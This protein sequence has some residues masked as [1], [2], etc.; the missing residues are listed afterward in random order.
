LS[1]NG[2]FLVSTPNK[3]FY[4]ESR[5]HEGP[6]PFHVHEFEFEEFRSE[7]LAVFPEVTLF[8]ENHVEAIAFEPFEPGMGESLHIA[9]ELNPQ[10]AHF[11]V[12]LCA[13][14]P[15]PSS[16]TFVYVPRTGN[17]LRERGRHIALLE[18]ELATKNAWLER[19]LREHAELLEAH[20]RQTEELERSNHWAEQ[21]NQELAERHARVGQLQNE[22]QELADGYEA[23]VTELEEDIR[24]KVEWATR[25][26]A[27]IEKELQDRTA[28]AQRL[29]EE[30]RQLE[31]QLAMVRASRW[32]KLG[33]IA[34]LGPE[35]PAG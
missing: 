31:Q 32:M 23:R 18:E 14:R 10:E 4:T 35:L 5:G 12:A 26:I 24:S 21:L 22:L 17:V 27:R 25:E 19:A 9:G 29:D 34:R 16:S 7:L 2:Q 30:R 6:N 13:H 20:R 8:L 3:A 33:R 15:Q 1:R 28:W 11:F